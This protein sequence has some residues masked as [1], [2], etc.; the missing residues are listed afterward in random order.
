LRAHILKNSIQF[1]GL[2]KNFSNGAELARFWQ[3]RWQAPRGVS[4]GKQGEDPAF[5]P[6]GARTQ[7]RK[8]TQTQKKE[9]GTT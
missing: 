9:Q 5:P 4:R 8:P 2:M 6:D 1:N 3:I 7:L